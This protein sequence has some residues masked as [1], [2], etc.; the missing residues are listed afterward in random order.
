MAEERSYRYVAID[1]AGRRV[2]GVTSARDEAA[3]F[4]ALRREGLSP[5]SLHVTKVPRPNSNRSVSDQDT[6]MLL[7]NLSSLLQAGADMR[8]ALT[9][10]GSRSSKPEVVNACRGLLAEISGG[11]AL[12]AAFSR[13]F[14]R[15]HALV[16]AMVAAGEVSGDLAGALSR[17][18]RVLDARAK[19]RSK[20]VAILT[21][22]A[23]VMVSTIAAILA[24]LLFVL[25]TLAPLAA[26]SGSS[27]PVVLGI[28]LW[29]S[30][31][32]TSRLTIVMIAFAAFVVL[33]VVAHLTGSLGR[34][35]DRFL[36][37]GP[38]KHTA[39]ALVYGGF[40]I[41]L[42]GMLSAGAPMSEALRLATRSVGSLVGRS[43]LEPVSTL[44]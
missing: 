32:L 19:L 9:V 37:R 40:A 1:G 43:R 30:E 35:L 24:L 27:P 21:Y 26:A 38:A 14:Q 3:A 15:H 28:L 2:R 36:L 17:A 7:S 18:A 16:G 12:D 4:E 13:H 29:A 25:P 42:G 44:R 34:A 31:Q 22:P 8:T 20:L 6:V 39:G 23:F 5:L 10:L 11:G 41:A 33:M